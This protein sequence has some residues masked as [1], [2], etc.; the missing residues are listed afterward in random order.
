MRRVALALLVLV[1]VAPACDGGA[2]PADGRLHLEGIG[3]RRHGPHPGF[4]EEGRYILEGERA[5]L[6]GCR[7]TGR[8]QRLTLEA[9]GATHHAESEVEQ[10]YLRCRL[11]MAWTTAPLPYED[12]P[13]PG[14]RTDSVTWT[15][16]LP[17]PADP[18]GGGSRDSVR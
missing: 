13:G 16:T 12:T 14:E 10:D 15:I 4:P 5:G 8:S 9:G 2:P 1:V 6:L 11:L 7:Y 17:E 18:P 3:V